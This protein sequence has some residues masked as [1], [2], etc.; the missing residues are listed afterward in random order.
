MRSVQSCVR[1]EDRSMIIYR[2]PSTVMTQ[3]LHKICYRG[4]L[5]CYSAILHYVENGP[6]A[7]DSTFTLLTIVHLDVPMHAAMSHEWCMFSPEIK[8]SCVTLALSFG[9][10]LIGCSLKLNFRKYTAIHTNYITPQS[11]TL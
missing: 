7:L 2:T 5:F 3:R 8:Q 10:L 9:A 4:L 6:A 1:Y 11:T